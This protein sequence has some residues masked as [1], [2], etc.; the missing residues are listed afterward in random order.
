MGSLSIAVHK[1]ELV[2]FTTMTP[3][4]ALAFALL[5]ALAYSIP[6]GEPARRSVEKAS[7][8]PIVVALTGL[9]TSA[10]QLGAP[11]NALFVLAR[12]GHSPLSNEIAATVVFMGLAAVWWLYSFA[13]R[14][15]RKLQDAL[16][17]L[18]CIAALAFIT[19]VG[20][21]YGA[22]TVVTWDTPFTPLNLWLT[23]LVGGPMLALSLAC[24]ANT[25][26]GIQERVWRRWTTAMIGI[27][28]LALL[29]SVLAMAA[30]WNA[31]SDEANYLT[32]VGELVP[33]FWLMICGYAVLCVLGI[34][35]GVR[36]GP[37]STRRAETKPDS[38]TGRLTLRGGGLQA[39]L[40]VAS[41]ILVL[42]GIFVARLVFYM[43]HLTVGMGA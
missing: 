26:C 41:A 7:G 9:V 43:M 29:S 33:Q 12:V 27:S 36:T 18:S 5:C 32:S 1:L 22:R 38:A 8:V 39:A 24:L 31:L 2:V 19:A 17:L 34:T 4:G 21:A 28:S 20:L 16:A 30:Q 25:A 11:S 14:P 35:A 42:A 13:V 6:R 15:N 37:F 40:S 10:S 3:S 23:A